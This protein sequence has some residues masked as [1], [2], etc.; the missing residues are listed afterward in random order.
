MDNTFIEYLLGHKLPG[1]E[2]HYFLGNLDKMIE[3]YLKYQDKLTVFTEKEVLQKQYD[4]LSEEH[5]ALKSMFSENMIKAMIDARVKELT[6][7]G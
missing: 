2:S 5:T 1:V 6:G 4:R 7:K 3:Q